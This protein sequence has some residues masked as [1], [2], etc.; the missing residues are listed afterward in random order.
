MRCLTKQVKPF[1]KY[2]YTMLTGTSGLSL[3]CFLPFSIYS[4]WFSY[5]GLCNGFY[6]LPHPSGLSRGRVCFMSIA[7]R[8]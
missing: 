4:S 8:T 5:Y 3:F 6:L 2:S 1:D 7:S